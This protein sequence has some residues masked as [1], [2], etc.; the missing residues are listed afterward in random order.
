[1]A[2]LSKQTMRYEAIKHRDRIHAFNNEDPDEAADLF[3]EA[4]QP[5]PEQA[6]ALYWPKDKEFDT[7]A[8][9]ERLLKAGFACGLPVIEKG[10]RILKFARWRMDDPLVPGPFDVMQP[11]VNE[12][13]EWLAP[14]IVIVPLLAFDRKGHRL[15]YGGGYYDATLQ[16]LRAEGDLL[17]VGVGY[18]QQAVIFNLPA[19]DHDQ[20]LDWVVTPLKAHRFTD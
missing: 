15:G 19:E 20:R 13:T 3:F 17:A 5:Q 10:S 12:N 18:A 2:D 9:L 4:V 7:S 8:I 1:M 14:D 6:V 16:A 11:Q